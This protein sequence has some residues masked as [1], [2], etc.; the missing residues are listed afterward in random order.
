MYYFKDGYYHFSEGKIKTH[1][2]KIDIEKGLPKI[3]Y[4]ENKVIFV[5]FIINA[6]NTSADLLKILEQI[7]FKGSYVRIARP[8]P[9]CLVDKKTADYLADKN[10]KGCQECLYLF[11]KD[12]DSITFCSHLTSQSG[13]DLS[14]FKSRSQIWDYVNNKT[15]VPANCI[16]CKHWLSDN[17][18]P[19]PCYSQL[20]SQVIPKKD[21]IE[22][23]KEQIN[24]PN[25]DLKKNVTLFFPPIPNGPT[26]PIWPSLGLAYLDASIRDTFN[27]TVIDSNLFFDI[28]EF[29]K[30]YNVKKSGIIG[31]R[32]K[33]IEILNT[34]IKRTEK[35]KPDF[36]C[37]SS[38]TYNMPF[39]AEFSR[40]FKER[41]P[42]VCIILG[43]I[44]PTLIPDETYHLFPFIDYLARGEG[45]ALLPELLTALSKGES[46]KNIKGIS[47]IKE[48]KI[49]HNENR[50]MI[51]DLDSL[52]F[53]D[54]ENFVGFKKWHSNFKMPFVIAMASRGCIAQCA[55]CTVYKT[56]GAQRFY[57]P[58]Y[59]GHQIDHLQD[60]YNYDNTVAFMDDNFVVTPER[61]KRLVNH[62]LDK[63]QGYDWQ[64][65]GMRVDRLTSE[66][67][68]YF[69][70]TKMTYVGFGVESM[71][72]SSLE[73]M[74]K[75][76]NPQ[77][78]KEIVFKLLDRFEEYEIRSQ[79]SSI[80][81]LPTETEKD[82]ENQANFFIHV[83]NTYS[84]A[85]FD[86]API[87][88]HPDTP[89][90]YKYKAG[91]IDIY[92][93]P[94]NSPKRFYEGLFAD[95]WD[96]QISMVPN[97]YR[98]ENQHMH[99]TRFEELLKIIFKNNLEKLGQ[100][101][102]MNYGKERDK[103]DFLKF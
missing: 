73:F 30:W 101:A 28:M 13:P 38:W 7:E 81:G 50:P 34:L 56:W 72:T 62:I 75:C 39:V 93:R 42:D 26:D 14:F 63:Y 1:I 33:E 74:N 45:D 69:H 51:H 21:K 20:H 8:V 58:E 68:E 36:L 57:S 55:F 54:F 97:A 64:I 95:K 5:D 91:E 84:W 80:I 83:Y 70:K 96:H 9:Y 46:V 48:G 32:K 67:I 88:I 103:V 19:Y 41:N 52:N 23:T 102:R 2:Y 61:T 12:K 49:I 35:T 4:Q 78:Y 43:G 17:C 87:V 77:E 3:D 99:K 94:K 29:Y 76:I 86:V 85:S 66:L 25:S 11:T 92:R 16:A 100:K 47:Y 82:M 6:D 98:V 44:N 90:Y 15:S 71:N 40:T 79:L 24:L 27:S 53:M 89:L 10:P 59:V 60:L 37:I 31:A 18:S 22:E 65:V